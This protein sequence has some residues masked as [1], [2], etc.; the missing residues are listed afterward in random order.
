MDQAQLKAEICGKTAVLVGCISR[1]RL[2]VRSGQ[3]FADIAPPSPF[4][5]NGTLKRDSDFIFSP[6]ARNDVVL[7]STYFDWQLLLKPSDYILRAATVMRNEP[8]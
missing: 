6:G 3:S 2:D 5:S 7:V 1:L 8:F 4:N